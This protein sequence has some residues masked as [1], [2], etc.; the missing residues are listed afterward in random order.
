MSFFRG[1]LGGR[2]AASSEFT[3]AVKTTLTDTAE[4]AFETVAGGRIYIPSDSNITTLDF[5]DSYKKGGAYF[6]SMDGSSMTAPAAIQLTVAAGQSYLIPE[7]LFGC[8]AFKMVGD[9]AGTVYISRKG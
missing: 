6:V 7:A 2:D 3:F 5:Y 9:A 8:G 1:F 4:V